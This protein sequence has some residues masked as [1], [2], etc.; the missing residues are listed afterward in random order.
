MPISSQTKKGT[1][2]CS[3]KAVSEHQAASDGKDREDRAAGHA[4]AAGRSGWVR[5]NTSTP[6]ETTM[7]ANSVPIFERSAKVPMFPNAGRNSHC[8]A[9]HP[10]A[11]VRRAEFGMHFRERAGSRPS[12]D[13]A[14]QTRAC[15]Y[16]KTRMEGEHAHDRAHAYPAADAFIAKLL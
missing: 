8:E 7:K 4:E 13:I 10:G 12:R 5:R 14:N 2:V 16:W 3:G 15:P 11:D 1:Q 9:R 6:T